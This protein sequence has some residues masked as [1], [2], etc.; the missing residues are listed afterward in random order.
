M[1]RTLATAAVVL[2]AAAASAQAQTASEDRE[3]RQDRRVVV[4]SGGGEGKRLDRD[5]DGA[6]TREEFLA[7]HTEMFAKLDRNGDGRLADD[8]MRSHHEDIVIRHGPGGHGPVIHLD[9]PGG[10]DGPGERHVRVIEMRHD[11]ASLDA[12][13]DGKT[14]FDELVAPMRRH[15]EEM[16]ADRSGFIEEGE[17][18]ARHRAHD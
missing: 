18:A 9:R 5:G 14:S 16:D 10:P 4:L 3:A 13:G 17:R 11:G 7:M 6:V 1:I 2:L 12:N 15:F 8:E